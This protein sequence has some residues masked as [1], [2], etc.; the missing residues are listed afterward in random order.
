MKMTPEQDKVIKQTVEDIVTLLKR[1][2]FCV[3]ENFYV[4]GTSAINFAYKDDGTKENK[5]A[6]VFRICIG[7]QYPS[8]KNL[9]ATIHH[10][11]GSLI[12]NTCKLRRAEFSDWLQPYTIQ[13]IMYNMVHRPPS[14]TDLQKAG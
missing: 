11:E 2:D 3:R 1:E 4:E 7:Y 13:G 9:Y 8:D 14:I 10:R 5:G 6:Q 12:D